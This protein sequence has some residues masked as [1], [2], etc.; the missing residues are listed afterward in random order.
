[1]QTKESYT[2]ALLKE[3][4]STEIALLNFAI[5][6]NPDHVQYYEMFH[7]GEYKECF[8]YLM[9]HR[10][11]LTIANVPEKWLAQANRAIES[12]KAIKRES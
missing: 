1:M 12:M 2:A 6:Y 10:G 5:Y 3:L 9:E 4:T 7:R 8:D 11:G